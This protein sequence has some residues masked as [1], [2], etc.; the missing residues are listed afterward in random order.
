MPDDEKLAKL[1]LIERLFLTLTIALKH[2][3]INKQFFQENQGAIT[4]SSMS[5]GIAY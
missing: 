5:S 3:S 2:C 1:E 4:L